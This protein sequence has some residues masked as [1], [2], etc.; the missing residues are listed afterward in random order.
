[1]SIDYQKE[2]DG[3][4]TLC[5]DNKER[6]A[7]V[8]NQ[9]FVSVFKG[10]VVK[11]TEE[12]NLQGV[13]LTSA[14]SDFIAGADLE[15]MIRADEAAKTSEWIEDFKGQLRKLETLG[16]PVVAAI[17][18]SALGGG[19]EVALACHHRVCLN[20]P[21][22]WL[23]LPEVTLGLLPGAGGT[24]R[25]P[26][27]IGIEQS[28]P[29]L[30]EGKKLKPDQALK[31]GLIDAL[32]ENEEELIQKAVAFIKKN[33]EATQPWDQKG[34]RWPGGSPSS[35][36]LAQVWAIA[37]SMTSKKTW[38]KYEAPT[39]I[40]S[41][42]HEGSQLDMDSA[43]RMETRYLVSC[44]TSQQAKNM[45]NTFWFQLNA[46][47]KGEQ[48]PDGIEPKAVKK[49]GILGAGMMGSGIAYV[50]AKAGIEVVLKD[51]SLESAQKGKSYSEMLLDK[52][53][54][55]K[56][57][58]PEKKEA[59]LSLITPT[60]DVADLEG[61]DLVIE[62]VFEDRD[63]K[64]TV[65]KETEAVL[66]PAA[67]F[68]SNTSTLPISSLA[69][70]SRSEEKFIGLHFFSPVDKMKLVEI[71]MGEKTSKETLAR[72]FDYVLQIAK[73]P[74]VVNDS[75]GFY[76]SRVFTTY[77]LEGL[78]LLGE[79]AHPRRV[80]VAGLD[81]GMPV[82]PLPL[83]DEVSI[84]LMYKI[85]MATKKDLEASGAKLPDH[86]GHKVVF[87]MIEELNRLGKKSNEGF[88]EYPEKGSK[89]LWNGLAEH[90][91]VSEDQLSRDEMMDRMLYIQSLETV[92]CMEEEVITSASDAN[93]GSIFGWGFAP[94][95]GGTLQYINAVGLKKFA[96]RAKELASKYGERF[97]PPKLL[98][99]MAE[100]GELFR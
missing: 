56:R 33:P 44:I 72:A 84:E 88:Y 74:I 8:L 7:N 61:C 39:K 21:K 68:A 19:Y 1:M 34:F 86:P 3:I 41:C 28:L 53:I 83:S 45:I 12:E 10:A 60:Q 81:A 71:I 90:F 52:A 20:N 62:A 75:R 65:T 85:L 99:E 51:V 37:P 4:V 73:T 64:A 67:V 70:A 13:I 2:K 94:F 16:V 5:F 76:T 66:D 27:I 63:L 18:G 35:P 48:R 82:G 55:R 14:K 36:K 79:G 42:V 59:L 80:E 43:L 57:S 87:H 11:L 89:S 50:S 22:I 6:G 38:G 17:N 31:A 15:M 54:E 98:I 30:L 78:A 23:G 24:Q 29:L 93:I 32:A 49:V 69:K 97:E 9:K 77:V 96:T 58:T 26:R 100:K 25:L 91:P 47:N 40:L 46:I 92:R 95:H